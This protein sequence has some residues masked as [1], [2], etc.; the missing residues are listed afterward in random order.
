MSMIIIDKKSF[1]NFWLLLLILK[2]NSSYLL[3][4]LGDAYENMRTGF[5]FYFLFWAAL[6]SWQNIGP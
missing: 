6:Y 4:G 3:L 2:L 1:A 5:F